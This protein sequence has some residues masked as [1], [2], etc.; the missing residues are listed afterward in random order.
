MFLIFIFVENLSS[1]TDRGWQNI[2]E[3][4]N[5]IGELRK[6]KKNPEKLSK[7]FFFLK[8]C[9]RVFVQDQNKNE[10]KENKVKKHFFQFMVKRRLSNNFNIFINT[11]DLNI[12][13]CIIT[14][15]CIEQQSTMVIMQ[16]I[17]FKSVVLRGKKI[18]R[19]S[20]ENGIFTKKYLTFFNKF[21]MLFSFS[22]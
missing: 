15:Y 19:N 11:T 16:V 21:F 22:A 3:F 17:I 18:F 6:H 8:T 5:L 14:I 20:A 4:V 12:I 7:T 9:Y 10:D 13:A 2:R 1:C